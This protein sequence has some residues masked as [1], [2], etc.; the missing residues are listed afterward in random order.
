MPAR[1]GSSS[2]T[3][4]PTTTATSIRRV[5]DGP[6]TGRRGPSPSFVTASC[7][8]MQRTLLYEPAA[9][10][11]SGSMTCRTRLTRFAGSPARAACSRTIC[12]LVAR[13]S[14]YIRF[15][16]TLVRIHWIPVPMSLIALLEPNDARR[17][18]SSDRSPTPGRSRSITKRCMVS[19]R[20]SGVIGESVTRSAVDPWVPRREQPA[21]VGAVCPDVER[22]HGEDLVLRE[23]LAEQLRRR[24]GLGDN[25]IRHDVLDAHQARLPVSAGLVDE[26]LGV[27]RVG[28]PVDQ[29]DVCPVHAHGALVAI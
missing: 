5:D 22:P 17:S 1:S 6:R 25:G 19:R 7:I 29:G 10:A 15:S 11:V 27:R 8:H 3:A 16:V 21:R 20:S 14:Q 2:P 4:T 23:L 12:S 18:A 9:V 28:A 13:Y 24:R 26:R